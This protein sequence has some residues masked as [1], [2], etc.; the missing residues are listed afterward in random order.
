MKRSNKQAKQKSEKKSVL[1]MGERLARLFEIPSDVI[2]SQPKVTAVGRVRCLL[3]ISRGSGFQWRT[4]C[5][6]IQQP[7]LS[8]DGEQADH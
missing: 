4:A 3:K 5:G 1:S 6:S 7:L 2:G 8:G